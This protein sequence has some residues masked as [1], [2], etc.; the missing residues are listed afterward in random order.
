[1]TN[2]D[3]LPLETKGKRKSEFFNIICHR[4]PLT[5]EKNEVI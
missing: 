3:H 1:M 5:A 4:R 2:V